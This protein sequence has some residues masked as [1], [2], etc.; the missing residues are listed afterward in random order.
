VPWRPSSGGI[1]ENHPAISD[2]PEQ[3]P[4]VDVQMVKK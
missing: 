2:V 4:T 1:V 3:T